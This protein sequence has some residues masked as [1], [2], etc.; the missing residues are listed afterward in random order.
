MC[1]DPPRPRT[2]Y[3]SAT[4]TRYNPGRSHDLDATSQKTAVRTDPARASNSRRIYADP[5]AERI[6]QPARYQEALL[7]PSSIISTKPPDSK[8]HPDAPVAKP[9]PNRINGG[10]PHADDK[11]LKRA[12][13]KASQDVVL[14]V[15]CN[16]NAVP[17]YLRAISIEAASKDR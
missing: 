14:P 17:A 2:K 15:A 7:T 10:P 6:H 11:R 3:V 9:G 12:D 4:P 16:S 8:D 5:P 1:H 13:A